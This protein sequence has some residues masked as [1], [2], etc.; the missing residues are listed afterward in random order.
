[1][2]LN[3]NVIE[4]PY[5][6]IRAMTEKATK[7]PNN[8]ILTIGEPDIPPPSRLLEE[9][10]NY[11]K[12]NPLRYTEAGGRERLRDLIANYYNKYYGASITKDNVIVHIGAIEAIASS[13]RT[14]LNP[15][16]EVLLPIPYFSPYRSVIE[17]AYG[18]PVPIDMKNNNFAIRAK[19]IE[20]YITSKTKAILFSNPCNPT[21]YMLKKE[22]MDELSSFFKEKDMFIISDEI[23]S[24]ISFYPFVSFSSYDCLKDKLI[25]V[26]GFS[27]SH[28][29]T[30]WR[31]GYSI[32]PLNFRQFFLNSS[33]YNIGTP[34][35]LSCAMAELALEK[36]P[37]RD[38]IKRIY[39]ERGSIIKKD[40]ADMGFDLVE[41]RGAFYL[42]AGYG[43]FSK[44]SSFDFALRLLDKT[45]VAVVPG[46]AFGIDG[47]FRLSLTK[48]LNI[49]KEAISRIKTFILC[50]G[51]T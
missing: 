42:F 14:I 36:F 11:A 22:E 6:Y 41:P 8:I 23:Y 38:D 39:G 46:E 16:D 25:V 31:I 47:Y 28:S 50:T 21:G 4:V 27:K 1:M 35:A 45:S 12:N 44:E 10:V 15:G 9:T 30:G 32:V 13:L 43:R 40:L 49:L 7:L 51:C 18:V 3:K 20:K 17:L 37:E 48:D 29:M 19:I 5:P 24:S 26:N 2:K 34:V 33:F